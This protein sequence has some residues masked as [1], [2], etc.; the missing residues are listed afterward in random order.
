MPQDVATKELAE[1]G[2]QL[3]CCGAAAEASVAASTT[4]PEADLRGLL[5]HAAGLLQG[6]G[7]ADLADLVR[8]WPA[9]GQE[10][11]QEVLELVWQAVAARRADGAAS[12]LAGDRAWNQAG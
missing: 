12:L 2:L 8:L 3:R 6:A 5:D 7:Q 4:P 10:V 1:S 11:Q 9:L